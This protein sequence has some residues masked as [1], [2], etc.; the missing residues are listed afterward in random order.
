MTIRPRFH[1]VFCLTA[2]LAAPLAAQQAHDA[3]ALLAPNRTLILLD[4]AHGGPD[5]GSHLKDNLLEKDVT[6]ALATRLKATLIAHGFQVV[7]TRDADTGLTSDQ[8]AELANHARPFACVLLHASNSGSGP[9]LSTSSLAPSTE[10]RI[11]L[12]WDTAQSAFVSDSLALLNLTSKTFT[13]SRLPVITLRA[14]VPPIDSLTCPALLLEL[15]PLAKSAVT[16]TDYQ[17]TVADALTTALT[18]WRQQADTAITNTTPAPDAPAA[19]PKAPKP[20]PDAKPAPPKPPATAPA[21][22]PVPK[23]GGAK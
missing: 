3:P 14:S 9:Y 18:A 4:P 19:K 22:P 11:G 13:S 6:L 23:P 12:P 21:P 10:D 16:D 8:R 7:T 15:G 20:A 2:L 17:Q 1:L 5:S